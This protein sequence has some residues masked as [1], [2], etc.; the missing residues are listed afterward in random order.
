MSIRL[1]P[2]ALEDA[3]TLAVLAR[4]TFS[5]T[6]G[7]LYA[8]DDLAAFLAQQTPEAWAEELADAGYAV[9][10][11]E[12]DGEVAGFAKLGPRGLPVEGAGIELRQLYIL[13][14]WQGSGLGARMM[15]RVL[16]EARARGAEALWLSV[17]IDNMRARRFYARYGF[18]EVGRYAFMVGNYR[19]EDLILKVA[20]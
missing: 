1:R 12:E 13:D 18:E 11:A 7:H 6:F 2:A 9:L 10:L 14:R 20:L 15:E 19:D 16:A 4:R 5:E 8:A 3:G 17:F